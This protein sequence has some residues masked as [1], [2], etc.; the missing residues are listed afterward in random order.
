MGR[1]SAAPTAPVG[2]SEGRSIGTRRRTSRASTGRGIK[3]R[4]P[5]GERCRSGRSERPGDRACDPTAPQP[6]SGP[7]GSG[8]LGGQQP[9][10]GPHPWRAVDL[11]L[12]MHV[13][14]APA[15]TSAV[16]GYSSTEPWDHQGRRPGRRLPAMELGRVPRP[17]ATPCAHGP[18][19]RTQE[20]RGPTCVPEVTSPGN[21]GRSALASRMTPAYGERRRKALTRGPRPGRRGRAEPLARPARRMRP[22]EGSGSMRSLAGSPLAPRIRGRYVRA[23]RRIPDEPCGHAAGCGRR[24]DTE[25]RLADR[26]HQPLHRAGTCAWRRPGSARFATTATASD[27]R[28]HGQAREGLD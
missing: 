11:G 14:A 8:R 12:T 18:P 26:R 10:R 4:V 17:V 23:P 16:V 20:P 7:Q 21:G 3:T 27:S 5:F 19:R 24:A 1:A 6:R 25:R 28:F 22:G 9:H 15:S 13:M 2:R